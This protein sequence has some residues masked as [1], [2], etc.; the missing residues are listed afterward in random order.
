MMRRYMKDDEK[1]PFGLP[2]IVCPHCGGT[3][4]DREKRLHYESSR[5]VLRAGDI[6]DVGCDTCERRGYILV[7]DAAKVS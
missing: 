1:W 5:V 2:T 6:A 4:M 7:K 3:G